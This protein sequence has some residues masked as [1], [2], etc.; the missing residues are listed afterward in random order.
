MYASWLTVDHANTRLTSFSASAHSAA[1]TI[2][3]AATTASTASVAGACWNTGSSRA[4]TNTP[5]A[6]IVAAWMSALIGVGPA[7]ASGS[8]TCRGNCADLPATPHS[9][10]NAPAATVV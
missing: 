7:I 2:V 1:P 4:T 8:Q 9:S 5:A 6:T 10:S 3:A